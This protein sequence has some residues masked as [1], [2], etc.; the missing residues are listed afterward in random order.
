M[1]IEHKG[2]HSGQHGSCANRNLRN[3]WI[4][5][6]AVLALVSF[7]CYAMFSKREKIPSMEDM[8]QK[9]MALAEGQRAAFVPPG[10]ATCPTVTNCFP[11]TT[12]AQQAAF[13]PPGCA[14]C[15]TVTNCFPGAIAPAQQ[16]AFMR[17][18]YPMQNN[19]TNSMQPAAFGNRVCPIAFGNQ[20]NN[21]QMYLPNAQNIALTQPTAGI[22]PVIF[23]DAL[24][25]H[26]YRGV[27]EL[28]HVVQPDRAIPIN[29][30]MPHVYRGVCSNCHVIQSLNPGVR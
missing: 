20:G 28:C 30:Q 26:Q 24:M 22:A 14:N 3:F 17:P 2:H 15:P 5:G 8:P 7:F 25:P 1:T 11:G 6:L 4:I 16:A 12:A 9:I 23:R 13:V 19:S 18:N 21:A 27:C 29:A 10:C